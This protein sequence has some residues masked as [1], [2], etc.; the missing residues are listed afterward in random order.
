MTESKSQ[1]AQKQGGISREEKGSSVK[2]NQNKR[3]IKKSTSL[4]KEYNFF[5]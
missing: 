2:G 3:E 1:R 5:S 4:D